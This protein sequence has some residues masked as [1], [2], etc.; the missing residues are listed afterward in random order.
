MS[1]SLRIKAP[2]FKFS[3]T[4]NSGNVPLPWGT[5]ATPRRTIS[6]GSNFLIDWPLISMRPSVST[7]PEIERRVVVFPAPFAPKTTTISLSKTLRSIPWS[8]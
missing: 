3:S 7:I 6:E 4:V 8:T 2:T 5:W 1:L